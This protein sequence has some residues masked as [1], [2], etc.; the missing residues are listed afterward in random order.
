M[1]KATCKQIGGVCEDEISGGSLKQMGENARSHV[2]AKIKEGD[3][4]HKTLMENIEQM[5]MGEK[6][7]RIQELKDKYDQLPELS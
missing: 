7:E 1:K 3:Q 4:A 5:G 2:M 6:L